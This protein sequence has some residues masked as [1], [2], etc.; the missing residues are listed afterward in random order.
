MP[1]S[2][3]WFVDWF[4]SPYYDLLYQDRDHNEADAFLTCL[5][6]QLDLP[7]AA[8]VLDLACGKGRYARAL[9]QKGYKVWGLDLSPVRIEQARLHAGE[10]LRFVVHDM[11]AW[12]YPLASADAVFNFFTSFGYFSNPD[13]NLR[14]L[15]NIRKLLPELGIFVLDYLNIQPFLQ[16]KTFINK[17][18]ING[19]K[20]ESIKYIK[21]NYLIKDITVV[22]NKREYTFQECLQLL[23][24][25]SFKWLFDQAGLEIKYVWGDYLCRPFDP[26]HSDRLILVGSPVR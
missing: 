19:I 5:I 4:N 23:D 8:T 13:D 1:T 14:V 24:Y 21:G 16:F 25:A 7:P 22:D 9:A 18:Y 26:G 2:R 11:R 10:N 17:K 3:E 12:P 20:F 15:K 6:D